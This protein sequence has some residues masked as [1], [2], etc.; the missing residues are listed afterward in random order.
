MPKDWN[1]YLCNESNK[2][3]SFTYLSEVIAN[4][5]FTEGKVIITT[6]GKNVLQV[7]TTQ[8]SKVQ[9]EGLSSCNH[10]EFDTRVMLHAANVVATGYKRILI[11]ANDTDIIVL[12]V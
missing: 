11:I 6:C 8:E 4:T 1:N 10:E 9:T 12:A 2:T 3:E 7:S 5:V